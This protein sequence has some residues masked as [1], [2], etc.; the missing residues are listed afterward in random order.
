MKKLMF[1]LVAV[2]VLWNTGHANNKKDPLSEENPVNKFSNESL[3][4]LG[5]IWG[6]LKY[7][8]PEIAA[9]KYNWDSVLISTLPRITSLKNKQERNAFLEK[10]VFQFGAPE[11]CATCNNKLLLYA[12]LLPDMDWISNSGFTPSLEE[13]LLYIYKNRSTGQM[14]YVQVHAAD[15]LN[16]L[17][18]KNEP[19]RAPAPFPNEAY[20]LLA[21]YRFWNT[22]AYWY[23]Y[24]YGMPYDWDSVL[25]K[26]IPVMRS[27][28]TPQQYMTAIRQ[29][30]SEIRDSHGSVVASG[31]TIKEF[32]WQMP[33]M[34]K[35]VEDRFFVTRVIN[36]SLAALSNLKVGDIIDSIDGMS[37][38]EKINSLENQTPASNRWSL[39]NKLSQSLVFSTD[40]I[41]HISV[42]RGHQK[43]STA[44]ISMKTTA[45][46][47]V[48][49]AVYFDWQRDSALV[50]TK[51][52]IGYINIAN[53]NRKD[54]A[55][56]KDLINRSASLI[57][58]MRNNQDQQYGT[59]AADIVAGLISPADNA[60][61][62]FSSADPDNPGL[63]RFSTATNMGITGT[64]NSFKG[65]VLI[66]INENTQSVG[67]FCTM[68]FQKA[69]HAKTIGTATAGADG[70]VTYLPLPYN[71]MAV[72]TGIGVYYPDGKE[73]QR[74]G[75]VPDIIVKETL[76]DY[77]AK[78]D[79][80]LVRA[81]EYF[82]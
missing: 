35:I 62:K 15:G 10:W 57:I 58:D 17:Q 78:R 39:L 1:L 23:P 65:R 19:A 11:P 69:P 45:A 8:H 2:F 77:K 72:F 74:A 63:F 68:A 51:N 31:N 41:R 66:L 64:E 6:F 18:F 3:F 71:M 13:R 75:I 76:E 67:E 61:V 50:Q 27:I 46:S 38:A 42:S 14:H 70:N 43:I 48:K 4:Q 26:Y 29:L 80:Q 40:S 9:G 28:H 82:N 49:S 47:A 7:H 55:K 52:G 73:T 79:I 25:K 21:L 59:G 60:F 56:L 36:D 22:I 16:V 30:V 81:I 54:S 33:V 12:K 5:K 32:T 20:N 24:K 53:F 34:G 37:I 44:I